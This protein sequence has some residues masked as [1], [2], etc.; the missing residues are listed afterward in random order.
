MAADPMHNWNVTPVPNAAY[1]DRSLDRKEAAVPESVDLVDGV[2]FEA[3]TA[4]QGRVLLEAEAQARFGMSLADFLDA[5]RA[6]RFAE[7][8]EDTA[9]EELAF[10]LPLA[11]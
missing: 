2:A 4:E 5:W 10:L 7:G 1:G 3:V 6:G 9:A 8:P 11:G